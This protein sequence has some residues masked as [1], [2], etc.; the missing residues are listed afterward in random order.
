M[1]KPKTRR[2]LT[3]IRHPWNVPRKGVALPSELDKRV[4]LRE[5]PPEVKNAV[6]R[7]VT[8]DQFDGQPPTALKLLMEPDE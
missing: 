2:T 6:V 3:R 4:R 1:M 8:A 7:E 5:I